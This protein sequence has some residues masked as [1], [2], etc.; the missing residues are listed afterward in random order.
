MIKPPF[1]AALALLAPL[2]AAT[3]Q[4]K[5]PL[6]PLPAQTSALT[7]NNYGSIIRIEAATQVPDYREPWKAGRFSGGIGTGFLIGHNR[8][9]TNAHVVSNARRLL[10]TVHGS[11]RK[12]PAKIVHIAHD[13]DL[14]LLE[15]ENFMPFL[16]LTPLQIGNVPKLESQV[17]VIGY[18]VG[19]N[20]ISVTRGVVSRI[21]FNTYSHSRS[22]QHLVVQIDAAINPGN[23]GGPVLQNGKVAGVAFQ[24]LRSAD[25]TGYMI[26]TPVVKRF[27]KDIEDG[28]YDQYV[29]LGINS[30]PMFNPAMRKKFGLDQNSPGVLVASVTPD[31]PCDGVLKN[32]DILTAINGN[33]VDA[34]G[35]ILIDGEKVNM[36]EIVERKFSGD[37][38]Q[39]NII[40]AGKPLSVSC[41]LKPFPPSRMYAAQYGVKPRFTTFAGLVLQP[42][43]RNLYAAH[44][45]TNTRVRRLFTHYV[46]E[47]IF[48]H[49]KDIVILTRVLADP[50]NTHVSGH[51]GTAVKSINGEKVTSLE[52]AHALLHPKDTPEFFIIQCE[53]IERPIVI[54]GDQAAEASQRT[55]TNYGISTPSHLDQ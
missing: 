45:F 55:Q 17:R 21:D 19:G 53:G 11:P 25:N 35:N 51:V 39:L 26:P 40:R 38:I 8:F 16:G 4:Q 13:C 12:H 48:K 41:T 42:L 10:I 33:A 9:L 30:F 24:G 34:A 14:A 28:H 46:D 36:N 52:Q 44:S 1:Y 2:T 7:Q 5:N 29:D 54:P 20:R 37:S 49:R 43:D 3:A 15:V 47:A 31:G 6:A 22:D 27:L 23:S 32:N 50:V 18:P